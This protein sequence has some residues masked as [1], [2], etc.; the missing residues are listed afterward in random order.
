MLTFSVRRP[1]LDVRHQILKSKVDPRTER[2]KYVYWP[3]VDRLIYNCSINIDTINIDLFVID[4]SVHV[5]LKIKLL[6]PTPQRAH[7]LN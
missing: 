4:I 5:P 6:L 7:F 3:F 2:V 1:T